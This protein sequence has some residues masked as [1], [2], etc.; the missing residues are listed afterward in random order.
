[1]SDLSKSNQVSLLTLILPKESVVQVSEA[2]S[3]AGAE[4]V[5]RSRPAVPS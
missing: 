4:G 5:F 2:V 3:S 1:M